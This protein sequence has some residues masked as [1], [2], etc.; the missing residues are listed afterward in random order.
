MICFKIIKMHMNLCASAAEEAV[1]KQVRH[2]CLLELRVEGRGWTHM[3]HS[4]Y[5]LCG[6]TV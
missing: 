5:I 4:I 1:G 2:W 6:E 3:P